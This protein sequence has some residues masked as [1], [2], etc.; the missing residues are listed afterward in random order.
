MSRV[1][2]FCTLQCCFPCSSADFLVEKI[3][4]RGIPLKNFSDCQL[5]GTIFVQC[6]RLQDG[7][8]HSTLSVA[9]TRFF[10]PSH[11]AP[12][13]YLPEAL[14]K[15][16]AH[17][18]FSDKLMHTWIS[19]TDSVTRGRRTKTKFL[20]RNECN[21]ALFSTD[22][23]HPSPHNFIRQPKNTIAVFQHRPLESVPKGADFKFFFN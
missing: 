8:L 2:C 17:F 20:C 1:H 13:V 22:R 11:G 6:F 14:T 9:S 23:R 12:L 4:C 15:N 5:S 7:L 19:I 18:V 3:H 10:V 21:H 16:S